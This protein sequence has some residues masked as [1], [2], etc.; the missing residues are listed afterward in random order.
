[1]QHNDCCKLVH[2]PFITACDNNMYSMK[3]TCV[4]HT[5]DHNTCTD[6]S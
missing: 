1:M 5:Y 4:S 2:L 6:D 3:I